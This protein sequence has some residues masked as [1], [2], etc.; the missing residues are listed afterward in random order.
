[1]AAELQQEASARAF[2][3]FQLARGSHPN[4]SGPNRAG[5]DFGAS[6]RRAAM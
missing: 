6:M 5:G 3:T 2:M 1:V 4:R